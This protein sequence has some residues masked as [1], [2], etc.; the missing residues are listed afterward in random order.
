MPNVIRN[1][2]GNMFVNSKAIYDP[3]AMPSVTDFH[4]IRIK[5]DELEYVEMDA[6]FQKISS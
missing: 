6:Y 3:R 2:R 1:A 4:R 5:R